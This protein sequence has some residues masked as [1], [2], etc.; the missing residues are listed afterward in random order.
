MASTS[1]PSVSASAMSHLLLVMVR[2]Y[3]EKGKAGKA[4]LE[5]MGAQL[6]AR[7]AAFVLRGAHLSAS[8]AERAVLR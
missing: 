5:E 4:Q 6:G 3:H 2:D 7:L 1:R 8:R